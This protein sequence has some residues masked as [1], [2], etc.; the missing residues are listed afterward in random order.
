[1][2]LG[3]TRVIAIAAGL[4]AGVLVVP[5][6]A[7]GQV[8]PPANG[9]RQAR[10]T[11]FT[12]VGATVHPEP[13]VALSNATIVVKDGRIVSVSAGG[14]S[15]AEKRLRGPRWS[16]AVVDCHGL[17]VYA[18]LIDPVVPVNVPR[19][20][21]AD[22]QGRH[23]NRWVTP[24]V[25]ATQGTG[26]SV[27]ESA[28]LR[29]LGFV[30]GGLSP[31]DPHEKQDGVFR[32][33]SA[34]IAFS[35]PGDPSDGGPR[36]YKHGAY[37][38]VAFETVTGDE[39][40]ARWSSYPSSNM[41]AIALVRQ[42]L[43]DAAY[44]ATP[45][46]K[47]T[48]P[49]WASALAN[50][51]GEPLL[52]DVGNPANLVRA[53]RIATEFE[54]PVRFVGSGEEYQWLDAVRDAVA[55]VPR[56]A[57]MVVLPLNFPQTPDVSSIGRAESVELATL[58]AWE[59]A[60]TNPSRVDE[61]GIPAT[62]TTKGLKDRK[63]FWGNLRRAIDAGLDPKSAH[64]MLT[65]KPAKLLGVE[66][67]LGTIAAGRWASMLVCDGELF[68][69]EKMR[70]ETP[71]P[72]IVGVWVDGRYEPAAAVPADLTGS[73]TVNIPGAAA[74]SRAI[75]IEGTAWE[76]EAVVRRD[77]KETTAKL[78]VNNSTFSLVFDHEPLDGRVGLFTMTGNIE[79]DSSGY[80]STLAG[81]G[82]AP[83]GKRFNFTASRESA[84]PLAGKW[85]A[86]EIDGAAPTAE[87]SLEV[88]AR[89]VTI[90][91]KEKDKDEVIVKGETVVVTPEFVAFS[92]PPEKL[93]APKD[94][95]KA[96]EPK[97]EPTD[98]VTIENGAATWVT[99]AG[100]QKKTIRLTRDDSKPEPKFDP[101]LVGCFVADSL[102]GKPA[103]NGP[104]IMI[105]KDGKLSMDGGLWRL[106]PKVQEVSGK[107]IALT[108]DM[109]AIGAAGEAKAKAHAEAS[110]LVGT[111]VLPDGKEI[112]WGAKRHPGD[113]GVFA[114]TPRAIPV[115]MSAYGSMRPLV[116]ERVAI[117][118]ATVW[119]SGPAGIL[120]DATVL[121]E[122]GKIKFVGD[123]A[124][125]DAAM[126]GKA[127]RTVDG[128]GKH[129]TSGVIDCHSH[130]S[131][132][133][134]N[135]FGQAV[136][137]EVRV[138][139]EMNPE[140]ENWYRQLASGVT[141][142]NTLHG[143][144][145]AIGGQNS[146]TK[147]RW[148][149]RDP[150]G[151]K[152]KEAPPGIKF[153]LGENP[154]NA[155]EGSRGTERYPQT[156]MGVEAL[157]RD[158]FTAAKEYAA[159]V[160]A[161]TP[162]KP[163]RRDLEL[164]A[165][166]QILSGERLL[167][168]HSYRQDEIVML[169]RVARDF[170][171]KI[172]TYQ[173]ILEGYKVAEVVRESAIGAS[174]FADWWGYKIEVQDAIPQAFALMHRLGVTASVNS[175]DNELARRLTLEA[176]KSTRYGGISEED[177]LKF[178][179]I[180]PAKQLKIDGRT[181]SIEVGKDADLA[182]WSGQPMSTLSRCEATW[183]E[184]VPEFSLAQDEELQKRAIAERQRVIQKALKSQT[185]GGKK[186]GGGGK[187]PGMSADRYFQLLS[188]GHDFLCPKAGECGCGEVR[189]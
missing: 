11:S 187:P 85:R 134:T 93:D 43:S 184:G 108:V 26:L 71:A 107:E 52:I 27:D 29:S 66:D 142:V 39:D 147:L 1:M 16:G 36:V 155:N 130:T 97:A 77:G 25:S 125:G 86:T 72:H 32:G 101:N 21:P 70:G 53:S 60:P 153:A 143:S 65:T 68:V 154:R 129:L 160:K 40:V 20:M 92:R 103:P 9:P 176:V 137:A 116:P 121:V 4:C 59:Q 113:P 84:M 19:P 74:A 28:G 55:A 31:V 24:G 180:N 8:S 105:D 94:T 158:R 80:A 149:T 83:D 48:A 114:E 135:E 102:D 90:R 75:V 81:T 140:N 15:P 145:N 183:V 61:A 17:H 38:S 56:G 132:G 96:D 118:G 144:A 115:P 91:T 82:V 33:H 164:E 12:L 47:S 7:V 173:H 73:W 182:L 146:V 34:V 127:W 98:R 112:A 30:A 122:D 131:L 109:T 161:A 123:K 106:V 124:G 46:M 18:G 120:K 177:A 162:D 117:V 69:G 87:V 35:P 99:T 138:E 185:P 186:D 14:D 76:P 170:G 174:G 178:V 139:D 163:V 3:A 100:G 172:G 88:T 148:G 189:R 10:P 50:D 95:K 128:R 166:A 159:A 179:T 133:S 150:L 37:Q 111:V 104:F 23:W 2:K 6:I 79:L 49:A 171:F 54:R 63:E 51:L 57:G 169:A 22:S 89:A 5:S 42:T 175:D 151:M 188:S 110:G 78:S 41:G 62:L 141:C 67:S 152:F 156:R 64:A 44:F 45:A 167:H 168:C 13:G 136:T 126:A 119:T 58:L 165:L 181:G 157:I